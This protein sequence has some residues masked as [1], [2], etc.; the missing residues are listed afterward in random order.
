[1]LDYWKQSVS[2]HLSSPRTM[3]SQ[4]VFFVKILSEDLTKRW[5]LTSTRGVLL[6]NAFRRVCNT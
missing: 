3:V 5:V 4:V 1:M 6:N 2:L